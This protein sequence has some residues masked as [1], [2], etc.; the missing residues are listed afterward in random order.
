MTSPAAVKQSFAS[1]CKTLARAAEKD[2]GSMAAADSNSILVEGLT[3]N[4]SKEFL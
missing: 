2:H 3:G 4:G 1:V